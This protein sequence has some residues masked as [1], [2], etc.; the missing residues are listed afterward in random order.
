MFRDPDAFAVATSFVQARLARMAER[1]PNHQRVVRILSIPCAGGEEP[2]SLAMSLLDAGVPA[3]AWRIDAVDLSSHCVARARRGRYTRNAFRGMALG[4]R[5]RHFSAVGNEYQINAPL[6]DRVSFSQG[7]LLEADLSAR[8]G[9]YDVI[10]CRNLLIY[11]DVPTI[12]IAIGQLDAMLADDGILFA[13]YAEV[14]A[15]VANGFRSMRAQGA[16]ALEKVG[17]AAPAPVAVKPRVK[18]APAPAALFT[19]A[20]RSSAAPMTAPAPGAAPVSAP[21]DLLAQ[22]R[23]LADQGELAAAEAAAR[24]ALLTNPEAAEAYFILGIVS[25]NAR[26]H[27]SA[28]AHW[29]RCI[30]LQPDHY[31]ALCHLALLCADNG[32]HAQADSFRQRAAR[33]Y[34]RRSS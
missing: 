17:D 20:P 3:S 2:Y 13:G 26:D 23:R 15:F 10:F 16:F 21:V 7:N 8:S 14:P 18:I 27:A 32:A 30:Y 19:T 9:R 1:D 33:V 11:F 4:F 25:E 6:R 22:A 12:A 29:R 34:Q 24:T 5:D 31:D 28:D